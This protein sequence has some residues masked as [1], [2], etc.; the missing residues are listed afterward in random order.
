MAVDLILNLVDKC[1]QLLTYRKEQQRKLL[2]EYIKPVFDEFCKQHDHYMECFKNYRDIVRARPPEA[3]E[4]PVFDL[5]IK[6]HVFSQGARSR[7]GELSRRLS[8]PEEYNKFDP[9]NWFVD[10]IVSYFIWTNS[11]VHHDTILGS[12]SNAPRSCLISGL[13]YI[14]KANNDTIKEL[15]L[16]AQNGR[17]V[18]KVDEFAIGYIGSDIQLNQL[19]NELSASDGDI[20][21]LKVALATGL[22]DNIVSQMQSSFGRVS[23]NYEKVRAHL[24]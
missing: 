23:E 18:W 21:K 19:R 22:I 3:K 7:L 2:S 24:Q 10:S 1:I 11:S 4:H 13:D 16:Q 9:V 14:F 12:H 6:D 8:T 17:M 5:I 20:S 15:S